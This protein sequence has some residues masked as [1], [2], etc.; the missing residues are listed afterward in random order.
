MSNI[1]IFI[2][3]DHKIVREGIKAMLLGTNTTV[4]G[5]FGH[6]NKL[7]EALKIEQPDILIL[8]L[9]LPG[10]SGLEIVR[11]MN[12]YYKDV[13]VI[14]LTA[15][16]TEHNMISTIKAGVKG[17]LDKNCSRDE[18][19]EAINEVNNGGVYFGQAS[20]GILFNSIRKMPET[21]NENELTERETEV[22]QCFAYGLTYKEAA[23]KLNIGTKTIETHKKNIFEKL[24]FTSHADLV[25]YAIREGIIDL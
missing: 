13:K 11:V 10:T 23:D 5:M 8:D 2:V 22:L 4:S 14:I 7:Y 15:N 9:G 25:K 3:D 18:L 1:T 20:S 24:N 21:G 6:A 12:K 17:F 19:L 16:T